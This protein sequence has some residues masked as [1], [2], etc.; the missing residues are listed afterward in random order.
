VQDTS[1]A[2]LHSATVAVMDEDT[3]VRRTTQTNPEGTYAI[4]G[5]PAGMYR[6]TVRRPGF[7]T[8][9]RWNVKIEPATAMKLDFIMQVGSSRTVVTV[10]GTPA[11][12]NANDASVGTVVGR[13]AA[14]RLPLSGRGVLTLAEL[15]AGVIA[16][17]AANGEAGQFSANGLRANTNYFTVDGVAANTGVGGGGLPAQ[18]AGNALPG[19]TA[20]GSTQNLVTTEALEEVRLLTSSFAPEHGRLPGAQVALT[21]RAG[22]NQY[23]GSMFHAF[24]NEALAAN[25]WFANAS[26]V[27]STPLRMNQWGAS[28]G[29]PLRRDKTF[30]FACYEG[31]RLLQPFTQTILT[32]SEATRAAAPPNVQPILNAFPGADGALAGPDL[33]TRTVQFS[34]P[35]RLDAQSLRIDHALSERITLFGRYNRAPSFTRSGFAQIEDFH[36]ASTSVTLGMTVA[37]TAAVTNDLR[38]NFWST[39]ASSTWGA[40]PSAGGAPLD[41]GAVLHRNPAATPAFYGIAIGGVGALYSGAGGR[42]RQRQWNL[43]DTLGIRRDRHDVRLGLDYQ[44]LTPARD[45]AA[46][47]VTGRW[48]SLADLLSGISPLIMTVQAEQASAMVET[49]S[50]FAQ[51]TW[52]VT[53]RL[54]LTYGVRWELTPAP[55]MRQPSTISQFNVPVFGDIPATYGPALTAIDALW[56]THYNQFAP[57][58]G[59]AF[60]AGHN[61]VIRAGWGVFYDVAF[62]TALDPINGFPFN[63]WQ[64]SSGV[65]TAVVADSPTYGFRYARDLKLPYA[66][67]WNVAYERM[68]GASDVI[69]ASYIG[70]SGHRL[71]RYEGMLQPGTTEAQYLIATNHG[72]SAYHGLQMQY[73]RRFAR[74]LQ[75]M[76][77]YTWS[78]S[79]DNGSS[80]SGVYLAGLPPW[81]DRGS[82]SFDVRHNFTAALTYA[83]PQRNSKL[84]QHWELSLILRAR[85]GFPV[86]V[87]T[88]EN[89]LGLGLDD[90]QRPDLVPGKPI[91][92]A[93]PI[94]GGRK[95]NP[96]AFATPAGF[97]GTLGRNAIAGAGMSQIDLALERRFPIASTA[98]LDFRLEAYNALNHPSASDPIRYLDNP[99][100]GLP[101]SM[102]N[103][104]L[105]TGSARS[106][107]TPA[108][109]IGGPRTLQV[110]LRFRF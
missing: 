46:E 11:R 29:G 59:A 14:D 98:S 81:A 16:T 105:G 89:F 100:F 61:S 85:T 72:T 1:G 34:R 86:D 25:D 67:Q 70:S 28:L 37:P 8:M 57:R 88:A 41:F 107:I 75:G 78:H 108:F 73:R 52:S 87:L 45:A 50:G 80:D 62:S 60:R 109:Q 44:R 40:D 91:W 99:L 18:F 21:T 30:I 102:L 3:G 36:L 83:V 92:L 53:P 42:N 27:A 23:H 43:L 79:I 56:T 24:R 110:Q 54:N 38:T 7:Q 13:S 64:F 35:S 103:L 51:D 58:I 93:D 77:A 69:S 6:I 104:M 31:L 32:P 97:Q 10:E 90:F 15:A 95:L 66:Q 106:G 84:L 5:L 22:S 65:A 82:S 20:F 33:A 17:P 71:L 63:R 68:L 12:M 47:S 39:T 76:A 55:T 49:L 4:Y 94:L 9:V 26:P 74:G 2:A 96:A 101:V 19:M 48:N